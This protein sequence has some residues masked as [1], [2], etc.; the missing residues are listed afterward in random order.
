MLLRFLLLS[1]IFFSHQSLSNP[2]NIL[3]VIYERLKTST[4]NTLLIFGSDV[5]VKEYP[6]I[7]SKE[8]IK[9]Q[10][11]S[12]VKKILNG[13]KPI[14]IYDWI[15]INVKNKN[16]SINII[17]WVNIKDTFQ[18]EIDRGFVILDMVTKKYKNYDNS[19]KDLVELYNL[20]D[21]VTSSYSLNVNLKNQELERAYIIKAAIVR[22]TLMIIPLGEENKH[23]N[24]INKHYLL[25]QDL[26]PERKLNF[27]INFN[28]INFF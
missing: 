2:D 19:Y 4:E 6:G 28:E 1:L 10:F 3:E 18:D 24:W 12:S 23:K 9:L 25:F 15:K 21:K 8:L 14:L 22:D 20:L 16:K 7:E 27:E 13:D 26:F 11:G 5:W 17:G